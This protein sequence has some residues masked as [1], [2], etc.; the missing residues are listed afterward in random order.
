MEDF[1]KMFP[2]ASRTPA[3]KFRQNENGPVG[4]RMIK[5][6]HTDRRFNLQVESTRH[7]WKPG[8]HTGCPWPTDSSVA[9]LF[10]CTCTEI[11][12]WNAWDRKRRARPEALGSTDVISSRDLEWDSLHLNARKATSF[13]SSSRTSLSCSSTQISLSCSG[14]LSANDGIKRQLHGA[15]SKELLKDLEEGDF[16]DDNELLGSMI[17]NASKGVYWNLPKFAKCAWK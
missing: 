4:T 2:K 15:I 6:I 11:H 1:G 9:Q 14:T 17:H 3:L 13:I 8:K 5:P 16:K 7:K 12:S 10:H